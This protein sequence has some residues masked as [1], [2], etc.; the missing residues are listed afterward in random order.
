MSVASERALPAACATAKQSFQ[1]RQHA[2][3]MVAAKSHSGCSRHQRTA[4]PVR[5]RLTPAIALP[6]SSPSLN[7]G[8]SR[9]WYAL[10]HESLDFG[11]TRHLGR[12]GSRVTPA[13]DI[14]VLPGQGLVR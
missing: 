1:P 10:R 6:A 5:C 4:T 12:R 7:R 3:S 2:R 14:E 13:Q 9:R 8:D 11:Q